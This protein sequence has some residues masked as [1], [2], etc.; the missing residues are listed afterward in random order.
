[1]KTIKAKLSKLTWVD[2]LLP[3]SV[4]I[5]TTVI[6]LSLKVIGL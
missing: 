6:N 4:I 2:I 1:M 3:V 5:L